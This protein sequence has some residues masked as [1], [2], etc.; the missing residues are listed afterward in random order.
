M[1]R[2]AAAAAGSRSTAV[3]RSRRNVGSEDWG[4]VEMRGGVAGSGRVG[5]RGLDGEE[6]RGVV[7]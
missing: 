1:E 6:E 2:L 3:R 5:V 4:V 7:G